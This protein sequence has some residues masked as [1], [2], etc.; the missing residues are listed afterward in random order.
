MYFFWYSNLNFQKFDCLHFKLLKITFKF[1]QIIVNSWDF[2]PITF[3]RPY[4]F[5]R[6]LISSLRLKND[7]QEAILRVRGDRNFK[8]SRYDRAINTFMAQY[9]SGDL[10]K[11]NRRP[12]GC[13]PHKRPKRKKKS[14]PNVVSLSDSGRRASFQRRKK[15]LI[16]LIYRVTSEWTSDN[17]E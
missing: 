4:I 7:T 3:L 17:G 14:A 12:G 2:L 5:S 13:A 6:R 8:E 15:T 10:R 11:S 9:P 1:V 16:C